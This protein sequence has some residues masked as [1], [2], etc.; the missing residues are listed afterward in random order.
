MDRQIRRLGIAF[1]ALFAVLFAQVAYVQVVAA[2]RI[3]G[4]PA[5][6][7]R[8]ITAEYAVER[9]QILAANRSTV[10]AVSK[11]NPDPSS[12]YKF[13]RF[14]PGGELWGQLTGYYSRIY[15]RSGLEQAMNP[16]LAGTAPEFTTQ[17]LTDIILGRPKR[18]GNVI[19]TLVPAVQAEARKALGTHEGAVVAIDPATGDI[20]AMY[21]NPGYDPSG[22]STG[23]DAQIQKA[24][25]ALI[26]DPQKPL[27][28]HAFQDLYLPGSTFKTIT[29]SAALDN[30]W[31]PEKTWKNPHHLELPGT[32]THIEN[33]GDEF[34]AGGAPMVTME[35]AFTSSCNVP[36]A[37]IG[38]ALGPDKMSTQAQAYG[39]CKIDPVAGGSSLCQD[40]TIPFI[41]PWQTGRF[42][43]ASYFDNNEAALA[44]SSI[45]LD[46]DL[47]NPL[48][49]GLIAAA[50]AN[51]GTMYEPRLVTEVRD[52]T[53]GQTIASFG[54][55]EYSHP[56]T[57]SS[58]AELRKMMVNVVAS[59]TGTPAQIPG[60]VVAGKTG[61]SANT[62]G[63][64]N[65]WFTA[66]APAGEAQTAR[67]A[68][69]VI[70]LDGG[71]LGNEATGGQVAAP[72][73]KQVIESYLRG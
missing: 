62:Q 6:A 4:E 38:M 18:G 26:G 16:Y 7:P 73:A 19:T 71:S 46:N 67:I 44:R 23:T 30:N 68:V 27:V 57:S 54:P 42:P 66:F 70:V 22:V 50:I 32:T 45:G 52:A 60:V 41:L 40:D 13:Q 33:F 31:P 39:L 5:N 47:L 11:P 56:L 63:P 1:V 15:G 51:G 24:W 17:N 20:L 72:I 53:T 3:A 21:S 10:L 29:A 61:T 58:A 55:Q 2:D 43:V 9:G 37:E 49:L 8:Q 36:F 25:Q 59:G 64:P 12:P 28:S 34:C 35:A 69:G 14:Y 48:H 65:A